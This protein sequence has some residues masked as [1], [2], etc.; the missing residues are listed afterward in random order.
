[1]ADEE[2]NREYAYSKEQL[3]FVHNFIAN[4]FK[5]AGKAYRDAYPKC[6]NDNSAYACASK[7]L[8]QPRIKALIK[9]EIDRALAD[10]RAHLE[11][12][13]FNFWYTRMTYDPT[14]IIDLTGV[15]KMSESDLRRKG[16]HVCIDGINRKLNAQGDSY[17]EYK[18]ADRD[19]AADRLEAYIA[20][21]KPQ[22]VT[23]VNFNKSTDNLTPEEERLFQAQL[24]A[25]RGGK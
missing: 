20:M 7:S 8:R 22:P 4:G 24:D 12:Q 2:K 16:L 11:H 23:N 19:K 9:A 17:V 6:S 25:I 3:L 18:L 15:L 10:K 14:E 13:I 1:M 5:D 21:I